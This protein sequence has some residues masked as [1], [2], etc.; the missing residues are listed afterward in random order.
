MADTFG[1]VED[2]GDGMMNE[3]ILEYNTRGWKGREY[4]DEYE[5]SMFNS[6]DNEDD[7]YNAEEERMRRIYGELNV[8]EDDYSI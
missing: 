2:T 7:N 8:P 5:N 3:D 6:S 1:M 4:D